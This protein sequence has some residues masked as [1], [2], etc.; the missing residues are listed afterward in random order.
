MFKYDGE[1]SPVVVRPAR[2]VPWRA[3]AGG[4]IFVTVAFMFH[5]NVV[6]VVL[7]AVPAAAIFLT[8]KLA[9]GVLGLCAVVAFVAG[10]PPIGGVILLLVAILFAVCAN[11]SPRR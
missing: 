2:A 6:G 11:E 8:P 5:F 4:V 3:I 1:P 10:L 9:L 7:F